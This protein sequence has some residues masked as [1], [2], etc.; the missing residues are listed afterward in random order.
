MDLDRRPADDLLEVARVLLL[1]QGSILVATTIEALVWR[2]T[3]GAAG[4]AVL[5][6]GTAAAA[7][8]VA[9]INLQAERRWP[10]WLIYFIEGATLALFAV[11]MAL[12]LALTHA[13]PPI[14]ALL[15]QFVLPIS[16]I[17]LL[18]RSVRASSVSFSPRHVSALEVAS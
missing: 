10:R 4:G 13:L 8:L 16:V 7:I 11:D 15:T 3:F 5:L 2:A 9:R 12:A 17:T 1:L 6:S 14:V 18:R